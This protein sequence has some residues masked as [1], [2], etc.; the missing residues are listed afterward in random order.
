MPD[1][2]SIDMGGA[3]N[4]GESIQAEGRDAMEALAAAM[5]NEDIAPLRVAIAVARSLGLEGS[6]LPQAEER[7]RFLQEVLQQREAA[8]EALVDALE[9]PGA[10][11]L[12]MAI[13]HAA[14]L[15]VDEDI[16]DEARATLNS[17]MALADFGSQAQTQVSL[18][19]EDNCDVDAA[20]T[21]L[22]LAAA[23]NDVAALEVAISRAQEAGVCED[24]LAQASSALELLK[25]L[26]QATIDAE[27]SLKGAVDTENIQMLEAAIALAEE[28]D[29]NLESLAF[30]K[31]KLSALMQDAAPESS[32]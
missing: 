17:R 20:S 24:T 19:T 9:A 6:L 23:G 31:S 4:G 29:V 26:A 25:E 11:P 30:A 10:Q 14:E 16:L 12:A 7:L 13:S 22:A 28:A 5:V 3:G 32:H 8:E 15:G 21:G 2:S 1:M 27:Q 18:E